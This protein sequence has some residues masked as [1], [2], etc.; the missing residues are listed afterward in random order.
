MDN[1]LLTP[2]LTVLTGAMRGSIARAACPMAM[3]R[4]VLPRPGR[5]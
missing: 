2:S 4:C 5:A 3:S 1:A